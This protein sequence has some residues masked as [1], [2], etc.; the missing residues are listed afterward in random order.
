VEKWGIL[1]YAI[2]VTVRGFQAEHVTAIRSDLV[3]CVV[4]VGDLRAKA[5]QVFFGKDDSV[6]VSFPYFRHRT[7]VLSS[8]T[9]P[10]NGAAKA[11]ISLEHGGKVTSHLVKY[12]HHPDGRAH[13]SQTGKIVTAIK[14]QSIPLDTQHGHIFSLIIQGLTG[15]DSASAAKDR[16]TS[17]KRSVLDFEADPSEAI[18]FVARCYDV[19]KLRFSNPTKTIGPIVPIEDP[20]GV[21][22]QCCLIASPHSNAK[23]VLALTCHTTPKLAAQPELFVFYGGFDPPER[24]RDSTKEA[25]F[26]AF[27]YP[28][29]AAD[30]LRER[31]GTVDYTP[32]I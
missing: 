24:M 23:H 5:F 25:G 7:G 29:S 30:Q 26:L 17:P 32:R 13:F 18:R 16:G 20:D 4:K 27:I 3:V 12:S 31:I 8:C 9:L 10:A 28:V 6:F 21:Q 15:L 11:E 22:R 14:R 2:I 1:L 19:N